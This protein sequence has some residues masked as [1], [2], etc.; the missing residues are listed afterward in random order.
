MKY[1]S[2]INFSLKV[3]DF[4]YMQSEK[5]ERNENGGDKWL[6]YQ[7]NFGT[8]FFHSWILHEKYIYGIECEIH[9]FE[10]KNGYSCYDQK[11][12]ISIHMLVT[13]TIKQLS[14]S[15]LRLS[16]MYWWAKIIIISDCDDCNILFCVRCQ[17]DHSTR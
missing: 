9:S 15:I 13:R 11:L 6:T 14:M 10:G 7:N 3:L 16:Q 4:G 2:I 17:I 12:S 5:A 1:I 8:L